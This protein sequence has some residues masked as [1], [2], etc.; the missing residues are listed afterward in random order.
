VSSQ[1]NADFFSFHVDGEPL[2]AGSGEIP[3]S[4][5]PTTSLPTGV[6]TLTWVYDKNST[7]TA[8]QDRAWVDGISVTN[9]A[10]AD[11][12]V[13][14]APTDPTAASVPWTVPAGSGRYLVKVST[15]GVAPWLGSDLSDGS[16]AIVEPGLAV[17]NAKKREGD[18]GTPKMRFR[19]RLDEAVSGAVTVKFRTRNG[20]ARAPRDFRPARG[21]LSFAPGETSETIVVALRGDRLAERTETF[22]VVLSAPSGAVIADP[23]GKGRIRND[24]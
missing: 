1:A 6:H 17:S 4:P 18:A 8:G 12:V 14:G 19:V 21:T 5:A 22:T 3:W 20:T 2:F 13:I 15:L 10:P 24:D 23:S 7:G 11:G 9:A 16:F